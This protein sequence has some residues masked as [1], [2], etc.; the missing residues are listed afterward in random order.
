MAAFDADDM[1]ATACSSNNLAVTRA[2]PRVK[3]EDDETR[4]L[5]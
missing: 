2:G 1:L 3:S 5:I 4:N